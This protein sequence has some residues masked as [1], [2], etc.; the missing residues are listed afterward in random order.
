MNFLTLFT[1]IQTFETSKSVNKQESYRYFIF[2]SNRPYTT[3]LTIL[4]SINS[5]DIRSPD[6]FA[7]TNKVNN[8]IFYCNYKN[9]IQNENIQHFR[10]ISNAL[11]ILANLQEKTQALI[12]VIDI[13]EDYPENISLK[14][15]C[16]YFFVARLSYS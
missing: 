13:Q 14:I 1:S 11:R 2:L 16:L 5:Q 6:C 12:L 15:Y 3:Y 9:I 8:D 4:H 7:M 10:F